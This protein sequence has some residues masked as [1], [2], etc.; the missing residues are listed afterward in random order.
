MPEINRSSLWSSET[1]PT[2]MIWPLWTT[3]SFL[4]WRNTS[5]EE[6][7]EH[8]GGHISCGQV[9]CSTTKRISLGWVKEVRSM[10]S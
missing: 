8:W 5:R 1:P 10:K 6:V 2:H 4:T 7:F 3:A 9:V